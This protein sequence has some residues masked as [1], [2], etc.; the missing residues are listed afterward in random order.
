MQR[1][2]TNFAN[3]ADLAIRMTEDKEL[4]TSSSNRW[5]GVNGEKWRLKKG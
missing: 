4:M 2:V 3:T 5:G 1:L